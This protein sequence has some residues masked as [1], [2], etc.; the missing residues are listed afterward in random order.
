MT[1][2]TD[3]AECQ[4]ML[5]RLQK[6]IGQAQNVLNESQKMF[7]VW[8]GRLEQIEIQLKRESEAEE[9]KDAGDKRKGP[10]L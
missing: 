7:W 8:S 1:I 4:Q 5:E 2:E 6:Q 10:V 9:G 3:K